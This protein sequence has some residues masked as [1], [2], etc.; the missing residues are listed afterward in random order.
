M[1]Q[2]V[3]VMVM[4]KL[5]I[6]LCAGLVL[7]L[8][9]CYD[10]Y[11]RY[12]YNDGYYTRDGYAYGQYGNRQYDNR[13]GYNDGYYGRSN[14]SYYTPQYNPYY[15][16]SY[17]SNGYYAPNYYNNSYYGAANGYYGYPPVYGSGSVRFSGRGYSG[18]VGIGF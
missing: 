4:K 10:P 6:L 8:S 5:A 16:G 1:R 17:Y 3:V 18:R 11:Y 7:G 15:G 13:Y 14:G 12:G 9:G 2:E